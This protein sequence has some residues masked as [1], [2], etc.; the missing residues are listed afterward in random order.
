MKKIIVTG[1]SGFI[2]SS[3]VRQLIAEDVHVINIDV[4]TYCAN[5]KSNALLPSSH[6]T[7][8]P[9]NI[10]NTANVEHIFNKYN[11]KAIFHLAAESHVD[12]SIDFAKQFINTNIMGTFSLLE[13]TRTYLNKHACEDFKFFHISTDEVYGSTENA[14]FTE[15]SPSRPSSPYSASKAA[16]DMLVRGWSNTFNIPTIITNCSNN[17]GPRQFPEKLIPFMILN[18]LHG[19]SLPIYGDGKQVRDWIHVDDHNAALIKIWRE[20]FK[21]E[22]FNIGANNEKTNIEIVNIICE[23]LNQF[24]PKEKNYKELITFVTDRPG[25]DRRYAIDAKK[26]MATGWQ[27]QHNLEQGLRDTI[28]WYLTNQHWWQDL[29]A[30][31]TPPSFLKHAKSS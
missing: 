4:E 16:S 27:P 7:H 1:G 17:Y 15:E 29:Y 10:C 8:I 9:E 2:G 31:L 21:N 13:A 25:H 5:P 3:L 19:K 14:A 6:Y 22:H 24:K 20:G 23:I 28:E 26:L 12:R 30:S 11:P 18:A